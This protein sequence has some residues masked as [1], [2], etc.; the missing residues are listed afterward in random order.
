MDTR[1][2]QPKVGLAI[3][4]VRVCDIRRHLKAI[5]YHFRA[6]RPVSIVDPAPLTDRASDL[7]GTA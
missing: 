6:L 2:R 1:N 5:G 7:S 4:V 3:L